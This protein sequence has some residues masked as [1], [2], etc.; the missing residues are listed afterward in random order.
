MARLQPCVSGSASQAFV[1]TTACP[2]S[3]RAAP[4]ALLADVFLLPNGGSTCA[5]LRRRHLDES[6]RLVLIQVCRSAAALNPPDELEGHLNP[7][8]T[9][10]S[11][12]CCG[13]D[14]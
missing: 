1:I 8:G 2:R 14:G 6:K 10:C 11:R 3:K 13:A 7:P 12:M 9:G 5:R 4:D